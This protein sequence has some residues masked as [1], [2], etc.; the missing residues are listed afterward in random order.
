[1]ARP[2]RNTVD[3]FPHLIGGGKKMSFIENKYGNDG[4]ATW[5]KILETLA[6]TEYHFLNL[7]ED[8]E[9]M[10]LSTKCKVD[11]ELLIDIIEDLVRLKVFSKEAWEKRVLWSKVFIDNIEDAYKRRGNKPL[12]FEGLCKHLLSYG[13]HID[14]NNTSN[15]NSNTQSRVEKSKVEKSR[16]DLGEKIS[17]PT[18]QERRNS[19]KKNLEKFTEKYGPEMIADFTRHWTEMNPNGKKMRFEMQTVFEISKRLITWKNNE[20]KFNK[21]GNNQ[22]LKPNG[23]EPSKNITDYGKL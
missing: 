14:N 12:H 18:L 22:K 9:I 5:F 11:E 7:N 6:S 20:L 17:P 21:N 1:M 2:Q 15:S 4:Y 10:F 19:F 23:T 13:I 3:Y 16:E 8:V